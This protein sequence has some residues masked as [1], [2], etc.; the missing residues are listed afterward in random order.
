MF[1]LSRVTILKRLNEALL[2]PIFH[3]I[4]P[5]HYGSFLWGFTLISSRDYL[6][7]EYEATDLPLESPVKQSKQLSHFPGTQGDK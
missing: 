6:E 3:V 1:R 2:W 4:S 7:G 5:P